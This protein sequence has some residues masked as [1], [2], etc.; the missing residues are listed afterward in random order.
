MKFR[1]K[2]EQVLFSAIL[3]GL[4]FPLTTH[5]GPIVVV[6]WNIP[7]AVLCFWILL[8]GVNRHK[9][10][11]HTFDSWDYSILIF[12]FIY[13]VMTLLG[14]DPLANF[15]FATDY[16]FCFVLAIYIRRSWGTILTPRYLII[17]AFISIGLE[18]IV[19]LIQQITSSEFGNLSVF[20]GETPESASLKSIG[21]TAM[22]RVHGTLGTG[23]LVGSWIN[24]F[25]PFVIF[26]S[27]HIKSSKWFIWRNVTILFAVVAVFLTISR[28]NIAIFVGML[29]FT[30]VLYA[31]KNLSSRIR[32]RLRTPPL[33]FLSLLVVIG[34]VS[35]TIYWDKVMM[36]KAAIEFRFSDTFEE[37][38]SQ[39]KGSSGIAARM[40]M[41]KGALQAFVRS[42][43]IGV[44]FKNSRWIW[45]TVDADVPNNWI[46]QPHNVYMVMLVEGGITLFI[47]YLLITLMPFY[48]LWQIRTINDPVALAF[49]LSLSACIG[50][51][52]IYITFTSTNFAAVYMLILGAAMGYT[53]HHLTKRVSIATG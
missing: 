15:F 23:N 41:N 26:S 29:L 48:R 10:R 17:L 34:I 35:T 42:P 33:I 4:L 51:Q 52:M 11:I 20:I 25:L 32:L 5:V 53:D 7:G 6:T 19:G 47:S 2:V 8:R 46:Y 37:V 43:I 36:M 40:E 24:I 14:Q 31:R 30:L 44:G 38:S 13:Y 49:F 12:G 27:G 9:F 18:S 22:G 21:E 28:F 39:G 16:L 1:V 50:I 45:P 3:L